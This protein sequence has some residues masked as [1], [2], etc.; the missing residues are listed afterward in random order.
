MRLIVQKLTLQDWMVPIV[1]E[2]QPMRVFQPLPNELRLN[3]S[4]KER[5][6]TPKRGRLDEH[7][8]PE[9]DVGFFGRS[10][11]LGA[12]LS[13]GFATAFSADERRIL[14]LLHHFQGFVDEQV[15]RAMGKPNIGNLPELAGLTREQTIALLDRAAEVGLLAAL[16][17]GYYRIHPALP[18]FFRR[19]YEE[20][21]PPQP[22]NPP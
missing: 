19:L 5:D 1:Y 2:A 18:W 9:P 13:Y 21:Y 10:K 4:I 17:G 12:A 8:P 11:S 16:G 7:L 6:A 22:R 3:I 15:L 14:A 20:F